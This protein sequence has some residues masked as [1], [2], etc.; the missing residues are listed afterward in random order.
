MYIFST[1]IDDNS[2]Q[3]L[4]DVNECLQAPCHNNATCINNMGGFRCKCMQ[5][6]YGDKCDQGNM[7][8]VHLVK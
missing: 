5:G 1:N 4:T 7:F 8:D 6:W 3:L 2:Y